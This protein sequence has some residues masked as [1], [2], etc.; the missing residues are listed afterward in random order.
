MLLSPGYT[1]APATAAAY[2]GMHSDC[3]GSESINVLGLTDQ[4]FK[5]LCT[6]GQH[7]GQRLFI[8]FAD[9]LAATSDRIVPM[10]QGFFKQHSLQKAALQR[11]SG[12][13]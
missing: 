6:V 5:S 10:F 7:V 11:D 9:C 1:V 2:A 13:Q 12:A 4:V 3:M 8:Q